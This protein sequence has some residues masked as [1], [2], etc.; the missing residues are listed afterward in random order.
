MANVFYRFP[1]VGGDT[2][3]GG[4]YNEYQL[5]STLGLITSQL[6]NNGGNLR[7][8][9][10]QIGIDNGSIKGVA[11]LDTVETIDLSGVS[12]E[13]WAKIEMAVS[14]TAPVFTATDIA[15]ATDIS[16]APSTFKNSYDGEKGG[17][18]IDSAKRCI[19]LAWKNGSG[20]LLIVI[21]VCP[22]IKDY[23]A[24]EIGLAGLH[25]QLAPRAG[26]RLSMGDWDMNTDANLNV[27]FAIGS[28]FVAINKINAFVIRDDS[29][30]MFP[31]GSADAAGVVE[32][33]IDYWLSPGSIRLS[34][35]AGGFFDSVD[36][37][38]TSF[39]RGYVTIHLSD[40]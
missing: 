5:E 12:N 3:V 22:H 16:E 37:D 24:S 13:T 10:G 26:F 6:Y 11:K 18:Y 9:V 15:G 20:N 17:F 23:W 39:N 25:K 35:V 36:F 19:G 14:G 8:R 30:Y 34:R 21:N 38:S 33:F 28:L 27:S 40:F 32:L 4:N 29:A 7:L 2:N 31:A 1:E